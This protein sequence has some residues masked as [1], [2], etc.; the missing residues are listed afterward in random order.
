MYDSNKIHE[1]YDFVFTDFQ[2][3]RI[4][5]LQKRIYKIFHYYI[6]HYV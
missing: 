4:L 3:W 6:L 5:T 1:N 2:G